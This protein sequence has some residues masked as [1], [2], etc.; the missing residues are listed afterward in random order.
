VKREQLVVRRDARLD[1][2]R[3]SAELA[4]FE[5]AQ[6]RGMAIGT[7]GMPVR[8]TVPRERLAGDDEH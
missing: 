5:L 6:E 3:A 7:E 2:P 8:E 1:H 4:R